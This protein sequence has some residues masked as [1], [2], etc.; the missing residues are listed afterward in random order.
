MAII[1][2]GLG[3]KDI[4]GIKKGA[5]YYLDDC[6]R[7]FEFGDLD[8]VSVVARV[9]GQ[10]QLDNFIEFIQRTFP[11][12]QETLAKWDR[13]LDKQARGFKRKAR[14]FRLPTQVVPYAP[15]SH[16]TPMDILSSVMAEGEDVR[17]VVVV[18]Q[19]QD[20]SM[21]AYWS[22]MRVSEMTRAFTTLGESIRT[23]MGDKG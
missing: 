23:E 14:I 2:L 17:G 11:P 16:A 1:G 19:R 21:A 13:L 20:R 15:K 4:L 22:K 8:V 7:R 3:D 18:V 10:K 9:E 6:W 12:N 5:R